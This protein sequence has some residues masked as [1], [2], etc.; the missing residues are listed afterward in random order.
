MSF[1]FQSTPKVIPEFTG[2]QVNTAVQ[3]LPI[4]IIYGTP[5]VNL[6]LIYYNGYNVQQQ[7]QSSGGKGVLTGGKGGSSTTEYFA[8][9]IMSIGEGTISGVRAIYQ[10]QAVYTPSNFP[11]N[12]AYFYEGTDTQT[13]WDYIISNWPADARGYKDTSYY[14]F[15]NSQLDSSSTVPQL[16]V[17]PIGILAGSSPLN[18]STITITTG[19]YD[20]NGNPISTLGPIPLGYADADPGQ[21]I[22]DFLTNSRY[23]AGFPIS[24]IDTTSLLTSAEGYLPAYGDTAISTYCQAV[25]LAWSVV[26]N[27]AESANSILDRWTTNLVVAPVWN[28]EVLRFIPY[29]N[30]SASANPG[31]GA[32]AGIAKKYYVPNNTPIVQITLDQILQAEGQDEDPITF[33]RKDPM[34]VYNTYRLD[35]RDR[36]NFFN[37]NVVEAKDEVHEELYGPRVDNIG[38]ANEYTLATYVNVSANAQLQRGISVMNNYTFKL[39]PLWGWLEPMQ[40]ISIPDP[41]NWGNYINVLIVSTEDDEDE[42]V[43][44]VAEYFAAGDAAPTIIPTSTTSPPNTGVT[45]IPAQPSI[46]P[47]I[48]EPTTGMLTATGY[49]TPQYIIGSCGAVGDVADP[50][51]AGCYI[52]LSL[53]DV[54][55]ELQGEINGPS[56]IGSITSNF[57][58]SSGTLTVDL[59]ESDGVLATVGSM[60]ASLGKSLCILQDASGFELLT[61]STSTMTGDFEFTLTGLYRGLYGTTQRLFGAGS[62][63]LYVG[64]DA[65]VFENP[66]PPQYIGQTV[67]I[68]LQSFNSYRNYVQDLSTCVSYAYR[69]IGPT[70]RPP[71]PPAAILPASYRRQKKELPPQIPRRGRKQ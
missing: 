46:A 34:E 53:D 61:Y 22:L 49:T 21:V 60:A 26:L 35:Y 33:S 37:D 70:P 67:Y 58:G 18:D 19:Q 43:T 62:K 48:F 63:F 9:L 15:S 13:A 59:G 51:W 47:V 24:L 23:G 40:I 69:P 31:W 27:N 50:Y 64:T 11:S 6:N 7:K 2:L 38:L 25:G 20:Q 41:A 36:T 5:R 57:S 66:M 30:T 28:G 10:D 12:G 45:N 68:K 39:S 56:I 3:V 14:G 1:L 17:L 16:N 55:F 32:S 54:N 4:P 8:T 29:W 52:W 65:N 42:N 71:V 44:V